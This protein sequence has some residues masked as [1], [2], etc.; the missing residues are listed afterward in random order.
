MTNMDVWFTFFDHDEHVSE[1]FHESFSPGAAIMYFKKTIMAKSDDYDGPIVNAKIGNIQVWKIKPL[2]LNP[3]IKELD[4]LVDEL[5]NTQSGMRP[6]SSRLIGS[7]V[8]GSVSR[9]STSHQHPASLSGRA[10]VPLQRSGSKI[11]ATLSENSMRKDTFM[12]TFVHQTSLSTVAGYSLS[13]STGVGRRGKQHSR[14]KSSIQSYGMA[15]GSYKSPKKMTRGRWH[16]RQVILG[17]NS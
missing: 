7:Q 17:R 10:C 4:K 9:W 13:I 15:D 1:Y 6:D 14:E 11:S 12:G 8:A 16:T 3:R 5:L 2:K